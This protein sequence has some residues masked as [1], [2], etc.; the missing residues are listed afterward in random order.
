M[1][2]LYVII[3]LIV[4]FE[5]HSQDTL[6]VSSSEEKTQLIVS[7]YTRLLHLDDVQQQA[8]TELIKS[9]ATEIYDK[10]SGNGRDI[11]Y[12]AMNARYREKLQG[13]LNKD[14][15][16][17]YTSIVI[18]KQKDKVRYRSEKPTYQFSEEDKELDF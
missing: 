11:D 7:K 6:R 15:Y 4:A 3:L 9:R 12:E 1:G 5:A 17:V 8:F 2:R 10:K 14:Q 13:I 16:R 18:A